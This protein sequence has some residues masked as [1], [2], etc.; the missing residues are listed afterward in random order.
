MKR[1]AIPAGRKWL[2]S[3]PVFDPS[4]PVEGLSILQN[5]VSGVV[6]LVIGINSRLQ[7]TCYGTGFDSGS[8][9]VDHW[10]YDEM[11]NTFITIDQTVANIRISDVVAATGIEGA[12]ALTNTAVDSIDRDDVKTRITS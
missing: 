11:S 2:Q 5:E 1:G 3:L 4:S 7:I 8:V 9:L 12:E 10:V 6:N